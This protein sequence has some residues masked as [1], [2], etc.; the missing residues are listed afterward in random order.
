MPLENR[1]AG[2]LW[3]M[4][5]AAREVLGFTRGMTFEA[6]R[7]NRMLQL[8][9]ERSLQILGE[10]ANRVSVGLREAHPEIPWRKLPP[11]PTD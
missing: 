9:V 2:Y 5:E 4:L 3:D 7:E 8:A 10:A 6:Y 11:L 1:D